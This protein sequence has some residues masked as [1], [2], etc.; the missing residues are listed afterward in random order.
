MV[1]YKIKNKSI[2][3]NFDDFFQINPY[4]KTRGNAFKLLLPKTKT[5]FRQKFFASSIVK[6]WNLLKTSEID[7]KTSLNFKRSIENLFNREN[8]R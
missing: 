8:I 6:Y 2:D 4:G 1:L 5:K 3:L 7:V